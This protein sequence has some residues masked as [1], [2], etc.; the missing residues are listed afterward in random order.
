MNTLRAVLPG[1]KSV[2]SF[3]SNAASQRT[4]VV[5]QPPSRWITS[6]SK[7]LF[8]THS[9]SSCVLLSKLKPVFSQTVRTYKVKAILKRRCEGC[10]FEKRFGRLYVECSL[11]PRHKQ[12]QK[13]SKHKLYKD[14][15]SSGPWKRVVHWNYKKDRY[16]RMGNNNYSRY[17]WLEGRL[18]TEIWQTISLIHTHKGA[19]YIFKGDNSVKIVSVL[20]EAKS[21]LLS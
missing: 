9:F 18:G 3:L 14:D 16:Y 7:G 12:M 15:Y 5:H 13:M 8:A 2:A 4:L 21:F 20:S 6:P 1:L 17:N 10:Y 19:W 11:K